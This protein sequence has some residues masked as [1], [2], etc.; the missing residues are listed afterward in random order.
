MG[1]SFLSSHRRAAGG[2]ADDV[3]VALQR[4]KAINT[5]N[6]FAAAITIVIDALFIA[7]PILR[8][9]YAS[10]W[11]LLLCFIGSAATIRNIPSKGSKRSVAPA[12]AKTSSHASGRPSAPLHSQVL[13]VPINSE[14][15][16]VIDSC[17]QQT[18]ELQGSQVTVSSD[19]A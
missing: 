8:S 11:L 6:L 1:K 10:A 15:T 7:V 18:Q 13:V 16:S 12:L 19:V 14:A 2:I 3:A 17:R 5:E 9:R 4:L